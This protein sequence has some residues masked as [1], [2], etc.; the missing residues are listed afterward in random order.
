[1]LANEIDTINEENLFQKSRE[2][3]MHAF[4][5]LFLHYYPMLCAY[6]RQFVDYEDG[7]EI[8]QDVMVW[9]WENSRTELIDSYLK[10]YLLKAV[11]NKCLTLISRNEL[12]QRVITNLYG[13]YQ[14][15]YEDPD[16]YIVEE[17]IRNIETALSHLPDSYREAFEMN[18][19]QHMTYSEIAE[20]LNVSFK[21]IDYR[22]QRSLKL[23]RA[24]LKDY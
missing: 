8:A 22:I 7:Q 16:C 3:D 2:G 19:F 18:R 17:L 23:L 20:K 9:L 1:M 24:E 12:K 13:N 21:T 15:L 11:R 14:S 5:A 4:E 6:A 10:C